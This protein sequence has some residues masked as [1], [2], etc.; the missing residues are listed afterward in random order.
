MVRSSTAEALSWYEEGALNPHPAHT[1]V[2]EQAATALEK[3]TTRQIT[4][5]VVLLTGQ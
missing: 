2:L 4:G 5:K 3:Q 1:F